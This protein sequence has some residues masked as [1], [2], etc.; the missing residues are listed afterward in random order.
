[1]ESLPEQ[2]IEALP[3]ATRREAYE[4]IGLL[5]AKRLERLS[6]DEI[7]GRLKLGRAEN[8]HHRLKL[9]GPSGLLPADAR[10]HK[11]GP[12]T[13]RGGGERRD[14]RP[15]ANVKSIFEG[16]VRKLSVFVERLPLRREHRQGERFVLS[17][18]KPL[19]EDIEPGRASGTWRTH[20][21]HCPMNTA[22]LAIHSIKHT[23]EFLAEPHGIQMTSS[24]RI[25][26]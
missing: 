4:I 10:E 2:R 21:M 24:R 1:M 8:M 17:R 15:A 7:A 11:G 16:V 6:E 19:L 3:G 13:A 23:A 14:L 5:C 18:A 25:W 9:W 22:R 20:R 26:L 12:P